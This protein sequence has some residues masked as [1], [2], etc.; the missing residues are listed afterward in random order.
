YIPIERAHWAAAADRDGFKDEKT[1]ETLLAGVT[2]DFGVSLANSVDGLSMIGG[3]TE[4]IKGIK[5]SHFKYGNGDKVVS[6]FVFPANS[7]ELPGDLTETRV[8]IEGV[9]HLSHNCRGCWLVYYKEGNAL[10]VTA[11]TDHTF[12]LLEFKPVTATGA[13]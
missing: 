8:E 7:L 3:R 9:C 11:T 1:T 2:S 6:A 13:I 5:V 10:V 12:K 4:E